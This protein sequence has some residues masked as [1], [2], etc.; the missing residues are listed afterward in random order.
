MVVG[1]SE[2]SNQ[3]RQRGSSGAVA[4]LLLTSVL[5]SALIAAALSALSASTAYAVFGLPDPGSVTR[6]GMPIARVLAESGAVV[7]IGSLL[8][9]AFGVPARRN[10]ALTADGYAAVRA[11]GWAAT[12]WCVS[13]AVL[14]PLIASDATGHP[15]SDVLRPAVFLDLL[16][17]LEEPKAWALTALIAFVVAVSCRVVLTWGWATGLLFAALVGLL[18]AVATGH[19]ASGGAHDIAT[20]SLLFH[21]VGA[22]LWVG[23][24]V[25]LLAHAARSGS[26]LGLV[27]R[28]YSAIAL[29]CWVVLAVSGVVNAFARI[30]LADVFTS[31]YGA[32]IVA[33]SVG[34]IALGVLGYFQRTYA[35]NK[36]GNGAAGLMRL[37]ATE[38]LIMFATIGV[39]VALGR[40]P[41]PAPA[42]GISKT[43]LLV[44]YRLDSPPTLLNL[45]FNI[46]FDLVY[47][48]MAVVMAVVYLIGVRRL[49]QRGDA[50][51]LGRT[52]SWLCG[53]ATIFIAT[54]AGIGR[55]APAMFSVHMGQH[56][57]M[58]MLAPVLLV[59]AGPTTLALRV[60]KPAGKGQPPGPREWLL[61]VLH[62]PVAKA[63]TNPIVALSLFVGS[64]YVLY[65]SGLFDAALPQHWAHLLMNAHFLLAG[66]VFY[67]PVIGID[68]APRQ[69]PELGKVGM[70]FASM[71]FHAFFGIALMMSKTVIGENFYRSVAL[72]WVPDLLSDQHLGGGLAWASGELPLIIVMFALLMQWSRADK[73]TA[74][75]LDRKA[76]A[77]GD[78]DLAAYNAM[79]RQL[80]QRDAR[81][82]PGGQ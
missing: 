4:V 16:D 75:R 20:N 24:L 54:S 51:P 56:M 14:V 6:F 80:A 25:A 49:R 36:I 1:S 21:Y 64:F 37:A 43:E 61:A 79:L 65:F 50:W 31:T 11:A 52:I 66:Y 53:C 48:T 62:S 42:Q 72:P 63:L 58:S 19:S 29:V 73:R 10:G 78:A 82:A 74:Q 71:P 28:R 12:V 3:S 34:L 68:P 26:H 77:D 40:T 69:L 13:A 67:W 60:L 39:A 76:E 59:L 7:S 32:L 45:L 22:A 9:A 15:V 18:P 30:S 17:A 38:I 8:L 57:L 55:Y 35:L 44:G 41:P 33:K 47:G 81:R 5:L 70:V 27:A 2:A 23:G 46:R